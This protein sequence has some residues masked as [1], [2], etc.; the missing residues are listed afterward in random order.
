MLLLYVIICYIKKMI[1]INERNTD[2][3]T[4]IGILYNDTVTQL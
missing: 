1:H 4:K 3:E 2:M